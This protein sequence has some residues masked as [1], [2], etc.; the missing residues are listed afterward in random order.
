MLIPCN[1]I[2]VD[3]YYSYR[4]KS[5]MSTLKIETA[6]TSETVLSTYKT[7]QC[8]NPGVHNPEDLISQ[9]RRYFFTVQFLRRLFSL[10]KLRW[11]KRIHGGERTV[12]T[13][14][15][16][17]ATRQVV[18]RKSRPHLYIIYIYIYIIT[19][20]VLRQVHSL[21][22][23][24]FSTVCNQMLPLSIFSILFFPEHNPVAA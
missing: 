20:S 23:S 16:Q 24:E 1:L 21:F 12:Y 8:H 10:R 5:S 2:Q 13:K 7:K 9:R 19:Y 18:L 14:S 15:V 4:A 17:S 3:G 11:L 22:Q 6:C